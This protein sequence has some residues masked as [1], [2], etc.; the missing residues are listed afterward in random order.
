MNKR[1]QILAVGVLA[2][3]ALYGGN[4]F[5]GNYA[6]A[7]RARQADVEAAQSKLD[8]A[9][10]K[11]KEGHRAVKQMEA[12]E[13]RALPADYD[14][15]LSL[16]KAWLLAKAKDSGLSVS[17]ISLLPSTSTNTAYRAISYQVVGSGSLS[18]VV[19]MLYEFYRSPQL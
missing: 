15:A 14:K 17:D 5:Y 8:E 3:V 9:D 7:L 11:L 10:H 13:Q 4:H 12:W 18:N 16:Y 19:S 1:E 6:K 2:L